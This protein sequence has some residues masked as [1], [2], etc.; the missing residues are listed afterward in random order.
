[1]VPPAAS[2][3]SKRASL[4]VSLVTLCSESH[5]TH[6]HTPVGR[7][8]WTVGRDPLQRCDLR[9]FVQGPP[10][11]MSCYCRLLRGHVLIGST[12][13]TRTVIMG[14]F[15]SDHRTNQFLIDQLCFFVCGPLV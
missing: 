3:R 12:D 8:P 7:E 11:Y 2:Q 6:T 1:M 5:I 4:F 13:R 10:R 14:G 15:R 9:G